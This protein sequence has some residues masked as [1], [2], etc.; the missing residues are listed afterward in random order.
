MCH[1]ARA[2]NKRVRASPLA[3]V[4]KSQC[5]SIFTVHSKR[6]RASPLAGDALEISALVHTLV[7]RVLTVSG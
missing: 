5:P 1:R 6:V 3:D 2:Y 4:L 7:A